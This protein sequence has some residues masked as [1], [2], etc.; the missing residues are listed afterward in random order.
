MAEEDY[1]KLL[2]RE[3]KAGQSKTLPWAYSKNFPV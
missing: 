1:Q 3:M 2:V